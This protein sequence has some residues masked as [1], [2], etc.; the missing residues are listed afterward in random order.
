MAENYKGVVIEESL[1]D[2]S[3]L[4]DVQ[5]LNTKVEKVTAEHK[6]PWVKQCTLHTVEISE[7]RG[8]DVAKSIAKSLDPEHPWYADFKNGKFHYIIFRNKVYK[9]DRSKKGQ[10]NNAVKFGL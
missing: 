2:K 10:Y 8:E 3:V 1:E 7:D 9:V 5:I 4:G 6:T